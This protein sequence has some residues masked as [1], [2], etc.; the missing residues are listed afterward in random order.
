MAESRKRAILGSASLNFA[1]YGS[2]YTIKDDDDAASNGTAVNVVPTDDG[3]TAFFESTTAGNADATWEDA[4]G[5]VFNVNDNDTPGG[6]Q[7]YFDEDATNADERLMCVSPTGADLFV[8]A[9]D[10]KEIKVLHNA[11]AASDGV[12]VYFDDDGATV[13]ERMLFVSPTDTD[14]AGTFPSVAAS[15]LTITVPGAAVGD[16]VALAPPSSIEDGLMWSG[17]VSAANT[18]T[19]RLLNFTGALI[20]PA[21]G[22]WQAAIIK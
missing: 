22:T 1:A 7:L 10:G 16:V 11:D 18:V 3:V 4:G 21:A 15:E 12:A 20:D 14:G 2:A 13:A 9:S 19:V 17:Y 8:P 6:V 5:A